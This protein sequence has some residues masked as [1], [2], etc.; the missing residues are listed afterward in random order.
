VKWPGQRRGDWPEVSFE[1]LMGT[2]E[3]RVG[4]RAHI[5]VDSRV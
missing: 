5:T 4:E 1:E 3:F 2:V